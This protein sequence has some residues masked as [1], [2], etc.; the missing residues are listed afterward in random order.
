M[1]EDENDPLLEDAA[2]AIGDITYERVSY[3]H[4]LQFG[5]VDKLE[6][7][8]L[9]RNGSKRR[10]FVVPIGILHW[11]SDRYSKRVMN[12]SGSQLSFL[13]S[14]LIREA[15]A[16]AASRAIREAALILDVDLD[17][18]RVEDLR[19]VLAVPKADHDEQW[20]ETVDET[21]LHVASLIRAVKARIRQATNSDLFPLHEARWRLLTAFDLLSLASQDYYIP[22]VLLTKPL[23]PD[24]SASIDDTRRFVAVTSPIW[25]DAP[26]HGW[27]AVWETTRGLPWLVRDLGWPIHESA[28]SFR[29][30]E[31]ADSAHMRMV[32]PEGTH[33]MYPRARLPDGMDIKDRG[34]RRRL[35]AILE[36]DQRPKGWHAKTRKDY[37]LVRRNDHIATRGKQLA[38]AWWGEHP[39]RPGERIVQPSSVFPWLTKY[40]MRARYREPT[41]IYAI[42]VLTAGLV[43]VVGLAIGS[44]ALK[45]GA[46]VLGILALM[47]ATWF[48]GHEDGL[49]RILSLRFGVALLGGFIMAGVG[50]WQAERVGPWLDGLI[51]ALSK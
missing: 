25:L 15:M 9:L 21:F 45:V 41:A 18:E 28:V 40:G 6:A 27:R 39:P 34:S 4:R 46:G 23:E 50:W 38:Q 20:R 1:A 16:E 35:L 37:R 17:E 2:T 51:A 49:R 42:S 8:Y 12:E 19:W 31:V 14:E 5:G 10:H 26:K 29:V 30:S 33:M 3:T 32:A 11:E 24:S 22:L 44:G 43:L 48:G 47:V 13:G 7:R 36:R